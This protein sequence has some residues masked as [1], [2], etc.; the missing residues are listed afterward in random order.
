MR[1]S[2]DQTVREN[3]EAFLAGRTNEYRA[4]FLAKDLQKQY[5][6]IVNWKRR[7]EAK[8]GIVATSAA[9]TILKYVRSA[10]KALEAG[11][12][13]S[14]AEMNRIARELE[15]MRES[16]ANYGEIR[17]QREI[18]SIERE[19]ARMAARKEALQKAAKK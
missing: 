12:E 3:L 7:Q 10:R 5:L 18:E 1:N 6:S 4:K 19:M 9:N 11:S 17:R 16:I 8:A 14:E 2:K 15:G 13:M